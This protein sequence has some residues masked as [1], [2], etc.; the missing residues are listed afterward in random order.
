MAT[1]EIKRSVIR[2]LR[3]LDRPT[4]QRIMAALDKLAEDPERRDLD[5][6]PLAGEPKD[7]PSAFRLRVGD[8]R[9]LFGRQ[10]QRDGDVITVQVI[11]RRGDAY[12]QR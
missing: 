3:R 4:R 12:K 7:V 9:V 10:Q 2:V 5:V 8:W 11:R 6:V 1:I